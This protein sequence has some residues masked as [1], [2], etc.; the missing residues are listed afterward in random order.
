MRKINDEFAPGRRFFSESEIIDKYNVSRITVRQALAMLVNEELV[1]REP[2]RGTF[3]TKRSSAASRKNIGFLTFKLP[4]PLTHNPFYSAVFE[5]VESEARKVGFHLLFKALEEKERPKMVLQDIMGKNQVAGLIIVVDQAS[6]YFDTVYEQIDVPVVL[7]DYHRKG[8]KMNCV[9]TDNV[10]GA[11]EATNYLMK[12]GHR[13]IGFLSDSIEG[14]L[15]FQER[16]EGYKRALKKNNIPYDKRLTAIGEKE[17]IETGYKAVRNLF[18]GQGSLLATAVFCANDSVAFGAMRFIQERG[19]KI[20]EDVSIVGFDDLEM[21]K[22]VNPLLTTVRV[23]KEEMGKN[24]VK[25]LIERLK[26]PNSSVRKI[27]M[28]TQLLIRNS[29]APP[30]KP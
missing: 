27:K 14:H 13:K 24:A 3:V 23:S 1:S 28:K 19:L 11:V 4:S 17:E 26:N 30:K 16:F 12:M 18:S 5:G 2:G 10:G 21:C 7:I 22:Y 29:V 25:L 15:S 8:R 9:I 6:K 20:P